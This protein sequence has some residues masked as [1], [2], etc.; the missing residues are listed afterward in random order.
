MRL[1][2]QDDQMMGI[3]AL[4]EVRVGLD[5]YLYEWVEGVD[6]LGNPI[7]FWKKLRKRA[8]SFL[9]KAMPIASQLAPLVPVYGSSIAKG[10]QT[11]TPMLK[12]AGLLGEA[13]LGALYAAPDGTLYQVQGLNA[14]ELDGYGIG[15]DEDMAGL[16]QDDLVQM[17]GIGQLGEVRAGPDGNLYQWL[18]GIDGLGNP[19]GFWKK[20]RKR[21]K[22]FLRKAMPI[23]SQLAPLVPVY[24]STI[25]K[26]LQTATPMLKRAGLLGQNGLGALYAAPDGTLYQVQG[27]NAEELEGF[28]GEEMYG[29]DDDDAMDGMD[30]DD[31]DGIDADDLDGYVMD[32]A[33]SGLEAY[34]PDSPPATRMFVPPANPPEMWAPPW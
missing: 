21:A 13:G 15:Q 11:A 9:R 34:V 20:L 12:R 32:Q 23:A 3:G 5:G 17:M 8:K 4:G 31:I 10:L 25:A 28:D 24:G 27:L 33:M 26:G 19:I 1:S 2:G 16:G 29:L 30:A 6:G 22:S 18:Q 14:E 7:G